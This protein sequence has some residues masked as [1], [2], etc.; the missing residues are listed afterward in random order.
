MTLLTARPRMRL[1]G[2]CL[3]KYREAR[4][5][6]MGGVARVLEC[7][8]SKVSRIETGERGIRAKELRELLAEYG[9]DEAM[10]QA[11]VA[12]SHTGRRDTGWWDEYEGILPG[13]YLELAGAEASASGAAVFAPVQ[14]PDLLQVP[15]YPSA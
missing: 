2:E 12:L 10:V 6:S 3:R 9:T 14:V 8:T 4:G 1:V 5:V 15:A 13:A 7:D 11:L